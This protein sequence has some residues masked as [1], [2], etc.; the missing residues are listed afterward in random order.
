MKI[1]N[2][3]ISIALFTFFAN[4]QICSQNSKLVQEAEQAM[5]RSTQFMDE[6]VSNNGGYVWYYL[7]DYSRRWGEMDKT[8][9]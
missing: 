9:N 7:P 4:Q 6:K 8:I 2:T 5:L 1:I 3:C